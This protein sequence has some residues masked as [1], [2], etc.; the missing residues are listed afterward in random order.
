M[1]SMDRSDNRP[2]G[3]ASP[4]ER[5][6]RYR[7]AVTLFE[8]IRDLPIEEARAKVALHGSEAV[9]RDVLSMLDADRSGT[10]R[11]RTIVDVSGVISESQAAPEI[12]AA[13]GDYKVTGPLGQGGGGVVLKGVCPKTGRD[14]AIKVLGIGAWSSRALGRFRQEIKL[15]GHLSHPGIAQ[16]LDAGTDRSG[17]SPHPYFVMEFVDGKGLAE[18]RRE[19]PRS[20]REVVLLFTEILEAVAFSH[21]RG[22]THRDLKPSNVLVTPDGHAKILDFGVA[23]VARDADPSLDPLRTLT[24]MLQLGRTADLRGETRSQAGT[25]DGSVVGTLPY[26]SPEQISG[27]QLVDARSDLYSIGVMMYEALCRRL[28]YDL[29]TRSLTDAASIIRSEIPMS[30]GRLDRGLRGD[31]DIIVSRL[32]E[33]RPADRYQSAQELLGDLERYLRGQ[34]ALMRRIPLATRALRFARR[35]PAYI[36]ASAV[37]AGVALGSLGYAA[38]LLTAERIEREQRT[39]AAIDSMRRNLSGAAFMIAQGQV[40]NSRT[41]LDAVAEPQRN[42]AWRAV[43]RFLHSGSLVSRVFYAPFSI[44]VRGESL[45]FRE[46]DAGVSAAAFD[47]RDRTRRS[48]GTGLAVAGP[49]AVSPD[50]RRVVRGY[51]PDRR[52]V[53]HAAADFAVLDVLDSPLRSIDAIDWSEDGSSLALAN[54]EGELAIVDLSTG[55]SQ[56]V[57]LGWR[58]PSASKVFIKL[59]DGVIHAAF[60]EGDSITSWSPGLGEPRGPVEGVVEEPRRIPLAGTFVNCIDVA[61]VGGSLCVA[62]GTT[63]GSILLMDV[64]SGK[65][66]STIEFASSPIAVIAIEPERG[67]VVAASGNSDD[68]R[69]GTLGAWDIATGSL[70]GSLGLPAAPLSIAFSSD[71]ASIF[72]GSSQGELM[73]YDVARDLLVPTI[74]GP[75]FRI[76]RMAFAGDGRM[77]VSAGDG[78]YLWNWTVD[79]QASRAKPER[80]PLPSDAVGDRPFAVLSLR[81]KPDDRAPQQVLAVVDRASASVRFFSSSGNEVG[82][83]AIDVAASEDLS[84]SI[85]ATGDGFMLGVGAEVRHY[86]A[87]RT[88]D[89]VRAELRGACEL[90][91]PVRGVSA[92]PDGRRAVATMCPPDGASPSL[93]GL[94]I[95]DAGTPS[96]DWT[97]VLAEKAEPTALRAAIAPDGS[98]VIVATGASELALYETRDGAN[99]CVVRDFAPWNIDRDCG[100]LSMSP[101]GCALAVRFLDG[102][103]RIIEATPTAEVNA[104]AKEPSP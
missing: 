94:T 6:D 83:T 33:K 25:A 5:A 82:R 9:R 38:Y 19:K 12:P 14:V 60:E 7:E 69:R 77:A 24:M 50:G 2:E 59:R 23:T 21:A 45:F 57:S 65:T 79:R 41:F 1:N 18:W 3:R 32:L 96:L 99:I 40:G 92:T 26:M 90:P 28:P 35:Y 89:V 68:A 4:N 71:G 64:A 95:G 8:C 53:V 22:I 72:A 74:G 88:G 15:L 58:A 93:A 70:A 13:I 85:A 91:M 87:R 104:R 48:L 11:V 97:R 46:A 67:L 101:D 47:L 10:E 61:K 102:S 51:V 81:V 76:G 78:V 54:R 44:D 63:K 31:L 16:I 49:L 66:S 75:S 80:W 17:V 30:M 52:L 39:V 37:L 20:A 27:T 34:R 98:C 36:A 55:R 73:V 62:I 43:H 56:R 100:D 42:W 103:V 84:D 86:S 29:G